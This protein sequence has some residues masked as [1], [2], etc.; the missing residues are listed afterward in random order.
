MVIA[1]CPG[2]YAEF[3]ST[4]MTMYKLLWQKGATA[5]SERY[6]EDVLEPFTPPTKK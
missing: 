3:A 2:D 5:M 4:P 6:P 1:L